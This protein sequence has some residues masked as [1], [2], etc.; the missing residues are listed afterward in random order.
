MLECRDGSGVFKLAFVGTVVVK[1]VST[2]ST[3]WRVE[4]IIGQLHLMFNQHTNKI[5]GELFHMP[6]ECCNEYGSTRSMRVTT[7]ST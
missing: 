5:L 3:N 4:Y 6:P 2:E 7:N 1:T